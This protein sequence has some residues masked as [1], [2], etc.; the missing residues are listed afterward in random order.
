MVPR[1][2]ECQ[3]VELPN[4]HLVPGLALERRGAPIYNPHPQR[5]WGAD[6]VSASL[7]LLQVHS[8]PQSSELTSSSWKCVHQG[9]LR[10]TRVTKKE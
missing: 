7:F 3:A 6:M 8:C 9:L 4:R 5:V 10:Q 2:R 1:E